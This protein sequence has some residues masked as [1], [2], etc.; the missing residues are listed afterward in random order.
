M[1]VISHYGRTKCKFLRSLV[2]FV[3]AK[4]LGW[5]VRSAC[6]GSRRN[7]QEI[8]GDQKQISTGRGQICFF[9]VSF[10]C[11]C[12]CCGKVV[13]IEECSVCFDVTKKEIISAAEKD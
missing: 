10:S 13:V 12:E 4:D 7:K 6:L 2:S 11:V 9:F 1:I 5:F 8:V 3:N